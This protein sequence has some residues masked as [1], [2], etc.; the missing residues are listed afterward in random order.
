MADLR[1]FAVWLLLAAVCAVL[2]YPPLARAEGTVAPIPATAHDFF[3][4]AGNGYSHGASPAEACAGIMATANGYVQAHG[5]AALLNAATCQITIVDGTSTEYANYSITD[6]GVT[7]PS[8]C[9]SGST[10]TGSTCT[11][12]AGSAPNSAG[13]ACVGSCTS[14]QTMS[15]GYYDVGTDPGRSPVILACNNGCEAV[16]DGISPSGSALVGGVAHYFA[17]GSYIV[18]GNSCTS[19]AVG[20]GGDPG[21]AAENRPPDT[22]PAG[23]VPGTIQ[24]PSDA[25]PRRVCVPYAPAGASSPTGAA[26]GPD[27]GR[28]PPPT[29]TTGSSTSTVTNPDGSTTTT[30]TTTTTR[31]DGSTSTTRSDRTTRPDG[32]S[33]TSTTTT[34]AEATPR[35][36][37]TPPSRCEL[38]PSDT[39]CGGAAAT[40]TDLRTKGTRT[41]GDVL[42]A[43]K[44]AFM[45][46]GVGAATSTFFTVSG[47]GT[48]PTWVWNIA[49]FN[50]SFNM[51]VFCTPWA[52]SALGLAR[53]VLLVCFAWFAFR[54]A[55]D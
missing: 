11:C 34:G 45:A 35:R 53:A 26:S 55:L 46:T 54:I 2:T 13:T 18:T 19:G 33:T 27:A 41:V 25:A 8:T 48:C 28:A 50:R 37:E 12:A 43:N 6:G 9:P 39:G 52:T 51:D 20:G 5:T 49:Y 44:A 42:T 31:A 7:G 1:R 47:A 10:L 22:C 3:V 14:G 16:F 21:T 15:S 38:N 24:G 36:D 30:T 29:S 32:S 23:S 17:R 40:V 4:T